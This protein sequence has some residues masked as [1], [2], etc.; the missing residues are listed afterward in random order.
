MK[1]TDLLMNWFCDLGEAHRSH[2]TPICI[3]LKS[4]HYCHS[5]HHHHHQSVQ[6]LLQHCYKDCKKKHVLYKSIKCHA[7]MKNNY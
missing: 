6:T 1:K 3:S 5:H 7:N 2:Q 4:H